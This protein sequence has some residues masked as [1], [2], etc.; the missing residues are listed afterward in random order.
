MV[1]NRD[2]ENFAKQINLGDGIYG[3]QFLK[4]LRK[5]EIE[6][7]NFGFLF[8]KLFSKKR[9]TP[10]VLTEINNLHSHCVF[11]SQLKLVLKSST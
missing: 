2:S 5:E 9:Y 4:F 8:S 10:W 3:D 7:A 6:I 1:E 11:I